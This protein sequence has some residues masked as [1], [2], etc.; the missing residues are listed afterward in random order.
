MSL[1]LPLASG[2]LPWSA[3]LAV[4]TGP[5]VG[6]FI[7]V[8]V[9]RHRTPGRILWGRSACDRC[10]AVLRVQDLVPLLSWV[11]LR[12]RCRRCGAPILWLLP[13]LELGALGV[14]F[15]AALLT[16][17]GFLWGS[18]LLGWTLLALAA[19]D[20]RELLLPDFLTLPLIAAGLA[21]AALLEPWT[22]EP[23]VIGAA[24][25]ALFV[26]LIRWLYWRLRRREGI[27]LGDAKLLAAA[28]AWV[29]WDGL[30]SVVLIGALAGLAGALLHR[31]GGARVAATDPVPFGAC[32]CFGLWIVW[33]YGP[34]A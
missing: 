28:G 29:Q 4:L 25:G 10:G 8:V 7:G 18:C 6:S 16:E 12:G 20:I 24:A 34:L 21:A 14:A 19:I 1:T 31:K 2:P 11:V 5:F 32:L 30:P 26:I 3:L 15:W 9:M 22:M 27:G 17:D 23:R 13:A 33:L